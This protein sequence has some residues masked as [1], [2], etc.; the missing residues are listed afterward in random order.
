MNF[1]PAHLTSG[2]LA[3][4]A[5]GTASVLYV[6]NLGKPRTARGLVASSLTAAGAVLNM[7]SLYQRSRALHSVPYRDLLG[8]LSLFG[9]FLAVL[10]LVL[11]VRHRD[12]SLGAFLVPAALLF[13]LV[14]LLVPP[15]GAPPAPELRG[16]LF[17]LHV[18]LNMLAY[19]AFAV[20]FCLSTLYLVVG[21]SLKKVPS[22]GFDG[23]AS[24]L[25]TLGYL[26][27]AN[28][29][30][31]G[32]G[33][34]ALAI[35]LSCGVSWAAR[36]WGPEH[37]GWYLDPKIWAA[38]ITLAFYAVVVVRAHRGAPPVVTARLTLAGFALVLLSY[39]AINLFV[40][41]LHSFT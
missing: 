13:L 2:L 27:R 39:T 22:R 26:E 34:L 36:V 6:Q 4:L 35:G 24:R 16:S 28:R 23:P 41:R 37:P 40:S 30:S 5:Y 3:I 15:T 31:L 17:A 20:A 18:T 9:F 33:V 7:T 38:F 1:V 14:A 32:V 10:S 25:P 12:R 21:R 29:T 8:S 11:E 19:A